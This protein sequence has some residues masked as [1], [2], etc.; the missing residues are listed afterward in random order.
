MPCRSTQ[1]I[2]C[3]VVNAIRRRQNRSATADDRE[4]MF[5]LYYA[6]KEKQVADG[7][8]QIRTGPALVIAAL[9]FDHEVKS[10]LRS[11]RGIGLALFFQ[12]FG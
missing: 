5:A 12:P 11:K 8:S 6:P 2:A 9:R 4:I 7:E 1:G 3:A 10:P